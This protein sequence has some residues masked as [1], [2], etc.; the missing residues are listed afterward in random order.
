MIYASHYCSPQMHEVPTCWCFFF[1]VRLILLFLLC[2]KRDLLIAFPS[3]LSNQKVAE[4][5]VWIQKSLR[6]V[7]PEQ[8]YVP[9]SVRLG[10]S[11]IYVHKVCSGS[12]IQ[13]SEQCCVYEL[14]VFL[15]LVNS[16]NAF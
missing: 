5:D 7:F 9:V 11:D 14:R 1:R 8:V 2:I 16:W 3:Q 13:F 4:V 12:S 10:T 15:K 6:C